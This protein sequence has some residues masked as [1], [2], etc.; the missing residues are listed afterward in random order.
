MRD[1]YFIMAIYDASAKYKLVEEYGANSFTVMDNGQLYTKWG[2]TGIEEA[3]S[4]FLGFGDKVKVT[5]LPEMA[6]RMKSAIY[7]TA[8][9]YSGTWHTV[10]VF[11]ML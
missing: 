1:D 8:Q 4:W 5:Q 6:E 11:L 7:R 2:F 9:R 10:V 3:V